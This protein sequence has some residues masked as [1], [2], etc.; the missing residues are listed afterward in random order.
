MWCGLRTHVYLNAN[1]ASPSPTTPVDDGTNGDIT[2]VLAPIDNLEINIAESFPPQVLLNVLSG[3][4][5]GCAEFSRYELERDGTSIR[6]TVWNL[7]PTDPNIACT[8]QY[9]T[10]ETSIALGS[11]FEPN[12]THV[13]DVN[14]VIKEF[15]VQ[16]GNDSP[17]IPGAATAILNDP[18]QLDVGDTVKIGREFTTDDTARVD[19]T[20]LEVTFVEVVEDS[21]CPA[22]V[23]CVRAGEAKILVAL[24]VDGIELKRAILT[25][26]PEREGS[27][28]ATVDEYTVS[29]LALDPY[30]GTTGADVEPDYVATLL[31]RE[32]TSA[33]LKGGLLATF[34]VSG[35]LFNVWVTS[36]DAIQQILNLQDGTSNANIPNGKI[37]LGPGAADHNSPW[38]WHL[39]PEDIEMAEL[40]VE[41]C[42]GR[43]SHV[44]D[45][46]DEFVNNV[47]RYCPWSAKLVDVK[48]NRS[49]TGQAKASDQQASFR[50][51]A[52]GFAL[53]PIESV[54][55][56]VAE[57]D[58]PQYFLVVV[59][60]LPNGCVEFDNYYL[61]RL[62][63]INSINVQVI[64]SVPTDPDLV[65]TQIHGMVETNIPLGSDFEPGDEYTVMANDVEE[66]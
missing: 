43:P 47:A 45:N 64:N 55:I 16:G 17:D 14:G 52:P 1:S 62:D 2:E 63:E 59:S 41:V 13:V 5:N 49:A 60:G 39:D 37:L 38:N 19:L 10:V 15:E 61:E 22:N 53:A 48:D 46:V 40:T 11:D 42:D 32:T 4:P 9:R 54:E 44:E 34:D 26:V 50:C 35:E 66:T 56:N 33:T 23:V 27:P 25:L 57:S 58:P 6:V 21:R 7:E 8:E 29:F 36:P 12:T 18:F 30:S 3:L 65:C 28:D 24:T 31:V 20:G 51:C